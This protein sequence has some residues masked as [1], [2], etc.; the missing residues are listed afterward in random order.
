MVQPLWKRIWKFLKELNI[1][2]PLDPA[3]PFLCIYPKELKA[4]F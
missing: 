1:E 2:L 3:T 4:G